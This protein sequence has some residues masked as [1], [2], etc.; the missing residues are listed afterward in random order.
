MRSCHVASFTVHSACAS[1]ARSL[2]DRITGIAP[3]R[4]RVIH[5]DLGHQRHELRQHGDSEVAACDVT[6]MW[7]EFGV[8]DER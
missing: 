5:H 8:E 3:Q 2:H 7:R 1:T 6:W 4:V